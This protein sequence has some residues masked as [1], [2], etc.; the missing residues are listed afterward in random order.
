MFEFS[1]T[2]FSRL[3]IRMGRPNLTLTSERV[4]GPLR[5]QARNGQKLPNND[6]QMALIEV[7]CLVSFIF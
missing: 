2:Q 6:Q 5:A 4:I 3:E 7:S 1:L